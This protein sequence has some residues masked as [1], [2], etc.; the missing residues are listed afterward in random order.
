MGESPEVR[1]FFLS[2]GY[3][4][5]GIMLSGGCG[6]QIAEWI[7]HGRPSLDMLSFD[8]RYMMCESNAYYVSASLEQLLQKDRLSLR[9]KVIISEKIS[10]L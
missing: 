1:G 9:V 4:S 6:K 10:C 8:I 5:S 3:N 2:C 7:V